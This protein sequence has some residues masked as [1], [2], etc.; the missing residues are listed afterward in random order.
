MAFFHF[1]EGDR[2]TNERIASTEFL[3]EKPSPNK[4]A[5]EISGA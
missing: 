4:K 2:N 1:V 3:G 5:P